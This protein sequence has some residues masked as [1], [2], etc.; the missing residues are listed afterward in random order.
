MERAVT[1][2]YSGNIQPRSPHSRGSTGL[3]RT[4]Y[5]IS[6]EDRAEK[7]RHILFATPEEIQ[8][9]FE[10]LAKFSKIQ[11]HRSVITGNADGQGGIVLPV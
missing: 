8:A 7:V 4:L 6:D 5:A 2:T 3:L 9:A 10:R 1:G 11:A